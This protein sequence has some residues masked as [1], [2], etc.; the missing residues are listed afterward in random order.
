MISAE[1]Q[2][3]LRSQYNPDG[4][5][6]RKIQLRMLD[7]LLEFDRICKANDITYWLDSG[8]LIGAARHGGFIPWDDD[9]DVCILHSDYKKLRRAVAKDLKAP[10]SF[11]DSDS[12]KQYARRWPRIVNENVII[13][14]LIPNADNK[15]TMVSRTDN[16]W[17]DVFQMIQGSVRVSRFLNGFYGR[18]YRR[19]FR[20]VNDGTVK[21]I[22]GVLLYPVSLVMCSLARLSGRFLHPGTLIHDF[23]AGFYSVRKR[24]DIFPLGTIEFEGHILPAPGNVHNYLTG[25]YGDY[26]RLPDLDKRQTHN[27]TNIEFR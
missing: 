17:I 6:L 20:L 7:I 5:E 10:Y 24:K 14:R 13:T 11:Y 16:L 9:L 18:C 4:S 19:R 25:V 1:I 27:F 15:G 2:N 23:G 8:T 26:M 22:T 21:H 3:K 12:R